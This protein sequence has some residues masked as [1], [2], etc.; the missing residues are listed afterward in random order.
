MA[1]TQTSGLLAAVTPNSATEQT[2]YTVLAGTK[3][4]GALIINNISLTNATL[5]TVKVTGVGMTGYLVYRHALSAADLPGSSLELR[6]IVLG[7]GQ[8][9]SVT[10]SVA[11]T[12]NFTLTGYTA[13]S[14]AVTL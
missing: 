4:S 7:P 2:L 14:S 9:M 10:S 5:V 6:A 11:N 13:P 8:I 1:F 3:M 12:A